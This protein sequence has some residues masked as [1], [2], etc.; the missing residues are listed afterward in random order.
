MTLRTGE[1]YLASLADGRRVWVSGEKIADLRTHPATA[2]VVREHARWYDRHF[3]MEWQPKLLL[4]GDP[5]T[6]GSFCRP[7]TID[8]LDRQMEAARGQAFASAGNISHPPQY[9]AN[10]ILG[11]FDPVVS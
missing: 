8:L 9:G 5:A 11:A 7:T 1:E 6:A 10:I 4:P 3:D 2:G